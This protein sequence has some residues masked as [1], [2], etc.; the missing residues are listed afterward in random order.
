MKKKKGVCIFFFPI[1]GNEKKNEKK[2]Y[3]NKI[4]AENELGYCP[5]VLQERHC[6]VI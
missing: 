5:M 4:G 1:A 2:K 3:N 6:I